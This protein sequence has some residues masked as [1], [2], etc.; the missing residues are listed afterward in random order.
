MLKK[1]GGVRRPPFT[2]RNEGS[3]VDE[4]KVG[5]R[6]IVLGQFLEKGSNRLTALRIDIRTGK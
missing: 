2:F 1:G 6:V 5:R 4:L 3:S